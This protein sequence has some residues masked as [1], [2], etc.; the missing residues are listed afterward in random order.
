MKEQY[1]V[2]NIHESTAMV[3]EESGGAWDWGW[4]GRRSWNK[5]TYRPIEEETAG[6]AECMWGKE[7]R[8]ASTERHSKCSKG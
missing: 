5:R 6:G 7:E 3:P 4:I 2:G 8:G 1:K